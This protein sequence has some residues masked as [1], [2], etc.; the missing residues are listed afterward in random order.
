MLDRKAKYPDRPEYDPQKARTFELGSKWKFVDNR[1]LLSASIFRTDITNQ[2]ER[3]EVSGDFV[4][5]GERQVEGLDLSLIGRLLS[6]WDV[7]LGDTRRNTQQVS[8]ANT[9]RETR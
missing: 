4:Q 2:V 5:S 8:G 7:M 9:R 1:F 3:D 6:G